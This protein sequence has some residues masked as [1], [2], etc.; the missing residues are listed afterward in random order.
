MKKPLLASILFACLVPA[1]AFH[2][3]VRSPV[4]TVSMRPVV[5]PGAR[6]AVQHPGVALGVDASPHGASMQVATPQG[7]VGL[8]VSAG[9]QGAR[10]GI[11]TPGGGISL[12]ANG[13]SAGAGLSVAGT[14]A[15]GNAVSA[16]VNVAR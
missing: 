16:S 1:C 9:P 3:I 15:Q 14:D 10:L 5:I 7:N 12:G 13:S 6:V 2:G 8:G 11:A 4:S